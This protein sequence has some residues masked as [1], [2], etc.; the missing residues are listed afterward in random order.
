MPSTASKL[1]Y[2][3]SDSKD[4]GI[5]HHEKE[6]TGGK[7]PGATLDKTR[8]PSDGIEVDKAEERG[9]GLGRLTVHSQP[10]TPLEKSRDFY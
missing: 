10:A 2:P 9:K 6:A 7:L 8:L 5:Q 1:K 3:R 4:E